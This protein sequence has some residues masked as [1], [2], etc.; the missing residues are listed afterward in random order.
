MNSP[1]INK[2][3]RE[4][5][6][7]RHKSEPFVK[8]ETSLGLADV[9]H[10]FFR[11]KWKILIFWTFGILGAAGVWFLKAPE[12]LSEAKVLVR[13]VLE[14][15]TSTA[16]TPAND[17][18][19]V[20]NPDSQGA[21]IL[22]TEME[23]LTSLDLA[24]KVALAVGP[25]RILS[26]KMRGT[27][28]VLA[29]E[30]I[31]RGLTVGVTRNSNV[32]QI[33]F[34]HKNPGLAREILQKLVEG[35]MQKHFEVH[36]TG[37]GYYEGNLSQKTMELRK[38]LTDT[39]AQLKELK[40]LSG[41]ISLD[42][43][44]R[45]LVQ[46]LTAIRQA[47]F[48]IEAALAERKAML[49]M[50]L[51]GTNTVATNTASVGTAN[52]S[53]NNPNI[54][55]ATLS[56]QP[57]QTKN[58]KEL[59]TRL[60]IME[61]RESELLSKFT[62][63]DPGV[64]SLHDRIIFVRQQKE[65]LEKENPGLLATSSVL[66]LALEARLNFL[67]EQIKRLRAEAGVVDEADIKYVEL[68]RKKNLDEA[69]LQFYQANLEQLRVEGAV[70]PG[71]VSNLDVVQGATPGAPLV[72]PKMKLAGLV[73]GSGF[74]IGLALAFLLE[75]FL[76]QSIKRPVEIKRKLNIPLFLSVPYV[77]SNGKADGELRKNRIGDGQQL[78]NPTTP[79]KA[80]EAEKEPSKGGIEPW[81][82]P[83][84]HEYFE[85]LRDRL[86]N[87]FELK[88]MTHKPKLVAVTSCSIGAGV[89]T[90][91][92]GLAASMSET[93]EGKVLLV[94]MT[95][96]RGAAHPFYQGKPGCPLADAFEPEKPKSANAQ[97]NLFIATA[98]VV[99]D[100]LPA[101]MPRK[102]NHLV[103]RMKS[104][105]YDYIIFD[106][107]PVSQITVTPRLAG[108]M[109]VNILVI[110]AE[111]DAVPKIQEVMELLKESKTNV[112]AV[113][114]KRRFYLPKSLNHEL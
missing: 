98:G 38:D 64:K 104:S 88:N 113:L 27:N 18:T 6:A 107:P 54:A 108:K 79:E 84:L 101:A 57:E 7:S 60:S 85:A 53:S 87:Y 59:C 95:L 50:A 77:V 34:R 52:S 109:D 63:E 43:T 1:E 23:I 15:K 40:T 74:F 106:M 62:T 51:T 16:A 65:A 21:S 5:G 99:G 30:V 49:P 100:K 25:E 26:G 3:D 19:Q 47:K 35:Y 48:T 14:T 10:I 105:D 102:F 44:K 55:S 72:I 110:E 82:E 90:M 33:K 17:T 11:H 93:G 111:K 75:L 37:G 4:S 71:K 32:L 69:S 70:G 81:I 103:P 68:M 56:D 42:D 73:L 92:A 67:N 91:A 13:Y 86:I 36:R 20:K 41:V 2:H 94:D 24:E 29:G 12:Y 28:S 58:Y 76:D 66:D 97:E 78:D 46:E 114:N 61:S 9:Y 39:Q 31:R 45:A 112:G 96:A 83:V 8:H 22:N 89:S 80:L